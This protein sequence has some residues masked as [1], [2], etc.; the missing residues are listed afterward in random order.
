MKID[1]IRRKAFERFV[2][3]LTVSIDIIR[4]L[5][6]QLVSIL[7]KID[8]KFK[9]FLTQ[10]LKIPELHFNTVYGPIYSYLSSAICRKACKITES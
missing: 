8:C 7:E 9:S 1:W 3:I 2:T 4:V 6:F 10:D 5:P